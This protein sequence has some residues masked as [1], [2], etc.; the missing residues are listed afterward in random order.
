MAHFSIPFDY[1]ASDQAMDD[2]R[3]SQAY[4]GIILSDY[5][6]RNFAPHQM[7]ELAEAVRR[8]TGLLMIGGWAS[9]T[10]AKREYTRTVL[11]EVLPIVMNEEDDRVNSWQPCVVERKR[12]H[13][14][15]DALPF[16]RCS[17]SVGGFNRFEAKPGAET[18]LTVRPIGI[19]RLEGKLCFSPFAERDP[20]LVVGR[21]GSGRVAAFASDVAPHWVGG[22]VDWGDSRI[23]VCAE[24]AS[25]REVGSWYADFFGNLI[26]WVT[27]EG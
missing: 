23:A 1:L 11:K 16:D 6:A 22:L 25:P 15:V 13:V 7:L 2:R 12:N 3:L 10:G 19:S 14:I 18:L 9:F 24:G 4:Q 20:L 5:P 17:P 8:G 27:K 21:F 26:R